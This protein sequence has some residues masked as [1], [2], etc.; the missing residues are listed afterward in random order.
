MQSK[1]YICRLLFM[2]LILIALCV[3][4]NAQE[5]IKSLS[6]DKISHVDLDEHSNLYI[7]TNSGVYKLNS[8]GDSLNYYG[9]IADG[10]ITN[11]DV[12]N[13]FNVILFYS[14]FGKVHILD[15]MFAP[16]SIID[17]RKQMLWAVTAVARSGDN[18]LWVYDNSRAVVAKLDDNLNEIIVSNDLRQETQTVPNIGQIMERD[19]QLFLLDHEQG[20][21]VL[22]RQARFLNILPIVGVKYILKVGNMLLLDVGDKYISYDLKHYNQKVVR[23]PITIKENQKIAFSR[24]RLIIYDKN[25]LELYRWEL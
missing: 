12:T 10:N 13:P 23:Y 7:T 21:Y 20:V 22:N 18:K 9:Y 6:K 2:S 1:T 25:K 16:Q 17:L 24:N 5:F 8:D 11:I 15:R 19:G 4:A 14:E 3:D